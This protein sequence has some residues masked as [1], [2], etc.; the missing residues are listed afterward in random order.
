MKNNLVLISLASSLCAM[1]GTN[2][3][4]D[5]VSL[6]GA[7]TVQTVVVNPHR[8]AV[9]KATGHTLEIVG[10]ATG[11]GLADLLEGKADLAM[12]SEPLDIAIVAAQ[13]SGKPLD[14]KALVLTE[15]QKAE[16]V[17]IVHPSNPVGSLSWAQLADI[18]TGKITNW[19]QVGG[20]DLPIT[21]YVD[22][23]T[24]GT[25]AMIKAIVM[26]GVDYAPGVKTQISVSRVAETVPK[27]E[28]GIGGV[29][30]SFASTAKVKILKSDK[31][32]R[33]LGFATVGAPSGKVK[34]VIDAFK[35]ASK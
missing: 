23:L 20:K 1:F 27:D 22:A 12:V 8:A 9:E 4:A 2:V 14:G 24:G 28:A 16:I 33:P 19:K 17:F 5:T 7:T 31:L 26:K 11:K 13:A 32:E 30:L 3:L 15:I 6:H 29:G 21:V 10:N 25:R 34:Q 18:H 35:A